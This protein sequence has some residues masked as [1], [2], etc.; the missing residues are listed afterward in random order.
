V[1]VQLRDPSP[2]TSEA[3][4]AQQ[5][6]R[7]AR[8]TQ[9]PRHS[10]G[11]CG[12]VRHGTYARRSPPG[13]RIARH[14][15]PTAQETFSLLPDCLAS[16]FPGTLDA[17]EA[18]V[19]QVDVARSIE[20]AADALRP[21]TVLPSAVRWVRR[22]LTLVRTTL[23]AVVTLVPDLCG[24]VAAVAAVR[25][26]LETS[27]AL[28]TLRQRATSL[29]PSLPRPLGFARRLPAGAAAR[30]GSPHHLGADGRSPLAERSRS[31]APVRAQG[32]F[33]G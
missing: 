2:L 4:V 30:R 12:F 8:L 5:A 17:L 3:Y 6:W 13:M 19:A 16:R 21:D 32:G 22:R 14:Y 10:A 26:R 25:Q 27:H 9:C 28:V 24:D 7:H 23:L 1:P 33:D 18:V 31:P 29:L 11:G 15:C 20:A